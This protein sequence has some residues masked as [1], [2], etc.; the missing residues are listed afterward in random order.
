MATERT[1]FKLNLQYHFLR[2]VS[3][4]TDNI[5]K[6]CSLCNRYKAR[7]HKDTQ[8]R[9]YPLP[10]N[11]FERVAM[12]F[13]CPL[14]TTDKGNKYILLISDY[15]TRYSVMFP[16]PNR[17]AEGVADKLRTFFLDLTVQKFLSAITQLNSLQ[18]L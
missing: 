9:K 4:V 8:L 10:Q 13:L 15:L 14:P 6:N 7:K 18:I 16:L 3:K 12:D 5:I 1:L 11:A 2:D 17:S